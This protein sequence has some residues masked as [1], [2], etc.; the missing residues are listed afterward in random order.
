[1][2]NLASSEPIARIDCIHPADDES[3]LALLDNPAAG[4]FHSPPWLRALADTY[5]FAIRAYIARGASGALLGGIPFCEI[6]DIKGRRIVALPFSDTCDP[7]AL[8]P[9]VWN[10]LLARLQS[11]GVPIHLRS[12]CIPTGT[13]GSE[14]TLV[15]R[16][17]W[18]RLALAPSPERMWAGLAAP[19]RRA[20]RK[21]RRAGVEI[22]RL[23]CQEGCAGFHNLHVALRK[24]KYRMLAQPPEFFKAIASR[25]G[26]AWLPL[27]AFLGGRLIAATVYL[28]WGDTLYYKFSASAQDTLAVRPNNLLVWD[29][30][31]L[32]QS[33]G[34]C[35]LDLGPSDDDQP[36]LIRF[37]RNFGAVQHELQFHQWTPPG[38]DGSH[39]ARV[40]GMLDEMVGL[41]TAPEV[42]HDITARAGASFYRLFA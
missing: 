8:S 23:G 36:G 13:L 16:A 35:T 39:S 10:A 31:L 27:G 41:L 1:M 11:H 21:A 29:G 30:I 17:R 28:R 19:T 4:L 33:L 20:I 26:E 6:D 7:L 37:K 32:A 24:S 3:W 14:V 42:P 40:R 38:W 12:L 9:D 5:G 2:P 34:C 15:K 22:R 25:F 18:H